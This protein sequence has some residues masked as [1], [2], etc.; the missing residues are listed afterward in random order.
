MT[1][2]QKTS[3]SV[4]AR[5]IGGTTV[6]KTTNESVAA[7]RSPDVVASRSD[8]DRRRVESL[9]KAREAK[10]LKNTQKHEAVT[11]PVTPAGKPNVVDNTLGNDNDDSSDDE[12]IPSVPATLGS[13]TSK[14]RTREL[15]SA[16]FESLDKQD[17]PEEP[18]S[19]KPRTTTKNPDDFSLRNFVLDK[20]I[21]VG[22]IA[23]ASGV[24]SVGIV[25]L[26]TIVGGQIQP[27]DPQQKIDP[28]FFK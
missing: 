28:S 26:K 15:I 27:A 18:P 4:P 5:R 19:K 6:E 11:E 24:A 22:R 23:V 17:A 7:E 10:R 25:I 8:A 21:D 1:D 9:A 14:K 2:E 13:A 20:V 3:V 12:P 16:L